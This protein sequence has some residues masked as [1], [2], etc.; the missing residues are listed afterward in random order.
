MPDVEL[1]LCNPPF[2]GGQARSFLLRILA[3]VRPGTPIVFICSAL[4]FCNAWSHGPDYDWLLTKP[5][6]TSFILPPR[7]AWPGVAH[8]ILIALLNMP[9]LQ[10]WYPIPYDY[11][12]R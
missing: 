9:K 7:N 12:D 1:V 5:P 10:P 3:I 6:I 2:S 8:P 11:L 4:Y